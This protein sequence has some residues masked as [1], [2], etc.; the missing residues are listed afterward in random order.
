VKNMT[1]ILM[2]EFWTESEMTNSAG[3]SSQRFWPVARRLLVSEY[4]ALDADSAEEAQSEDRS[5]RKGPPTVGGYLAD[6]W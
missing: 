5:E 4:S 3:R 2:P 6:I 1:G